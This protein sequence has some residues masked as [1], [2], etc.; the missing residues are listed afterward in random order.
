M[1]TTY[2]NGEM[3]TLDAIEIMEWAA[4]DKNKPVLGFIRHLMEEATEYTVHVDITATKTIINLM[5]YSGVAIK[6]LVL[7]HWMDGYA[8]CQVV[9]GGAFALINK[10]WINL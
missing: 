8:G 9:G 1:T 10:E 6:T 5:S 4:V 2:D 3:N 7:R